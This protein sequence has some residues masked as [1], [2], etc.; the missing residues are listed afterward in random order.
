METWDI[1]TGF[2]IVYKG[3]LEKMIQKV[4]RKPDMETDVYRK[5][6]EVSKR[7][8]LG[9][10]RELKCYGKRINFRQKKGRCRQ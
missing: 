7:R 5:E 2:N 4:I 6:L 8:L 3:N 1:F 10:Y 9:D